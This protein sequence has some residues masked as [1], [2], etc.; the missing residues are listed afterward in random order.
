[1][2]HTPGGK[3]R[4]IPLDSEEIRFGRS[5]QCTVPIEDAYVSEQHARVYRT[6]DGWVVAD[7]GST[8]GTYLNRAKV[9]TPSPLQPGDQLGIGK[10]VVEVRK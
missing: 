1:V 6:D 8:N 2:V 7:M 5:Q 9:T 3:P 4:V 10:T